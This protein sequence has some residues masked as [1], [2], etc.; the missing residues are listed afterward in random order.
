[1]N[2]LGGFADNLVKKK[3]CDTNFL[4]ETLWEQTMILKTL[5][6]DPIQNYIAGERLYWDMNT[7]LLTPVSN[8]NHSTNAVI[9]DIPSEDTPYLIF[10]SC[11][12][13]TLE[14]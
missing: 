11:G 10:E 7:E 13:L 14:Y 6:Y 3:N 4:S 1:M 2:Y 9:I 5:E 8:T 12:F